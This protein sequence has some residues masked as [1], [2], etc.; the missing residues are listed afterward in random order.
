MEEIL[1]ERIKEDYYRI[2]SIVNK[3]NITEEE[4]FKVVESVDFLIKEIKDN[5]RLED[6]SRILEDIEF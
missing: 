4:K 2:S 5:T 3:L 1:K 6:N